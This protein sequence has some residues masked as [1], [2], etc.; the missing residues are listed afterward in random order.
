MS[1][2]AWY[3]CLAAIY[4]SIAVVAIY[5][6][7]HKYKV[8]TLI[9]FYL[10]TTCITWIGEFIVLGIFDSYAYKPGISSDPWLE[11]LAGHLFL[12]ASMF[13]ASAIL[14][15]TY[16][17]GY[18]GYSI[19]IAGFILAEYVFVHLGIYEQHWWR[20]YMSG[21]NTAAFLIIARKWFTVITPPKRNVPRLITFYFIGFL[22][23]HIPSPFLLLMG[24]QYYSLDIVDKLVGN[25]NRSSI[26]IIF[27]YQLII[28]ALMVYFVCV[29]DKWYWKLL[30]FAITILSQSFFYLAG[31]L[32]IQSGWKLIYT[33]L[34]YM[35]GPAVF[36]LLEK[37]ILRPD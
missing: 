18:P 26:I 20:Y 21:I 24:K 32:V 1:N 4:I 6:S 37:Y 28:A 5:K 8:S 10:F 34:L 35:L 12:N 30:P 3:A 11:N 7:R 25:M 14:V 13:P 2:T 27:S 17:L 23:V 33:I 16:S 9:M 19:I 29:L 36:I 22:L 31:I 15:I